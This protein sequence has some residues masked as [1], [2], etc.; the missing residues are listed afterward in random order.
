MLPN[1]VPKPVTSAFRNGDKSYISPHI[2]ERCNLNV[3]GT[4]TQVHIELRWK[5]E[6]KNRGRS[7]RVKNCLFR[8]RDGLE[9]DL[10]IGSRVLDQLK[11]QAGSTEDSWDP[12]ESSDDEGIASPSLNPH[13]IQTDIYE[14]FE[15][16]HQRSVSGS[17]PTSSL[18]GSSTVS[19]GGH[20]TEKDY[21]DFAHRILDMVSGA[22]NGDMVAHGNRRNDRDDSH[23]ISPE[24]AGRSRQRRRRHLDNGSDLKS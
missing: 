11:K 23:T 21:L 4:G 3:G 17:M 15:I 8:V 2:L 19:S 10:A 9:T 5:I 7:Y 20:A 18:A 14:A 16:S 6:D 13:S 24:R 1:D 22:R 12:D